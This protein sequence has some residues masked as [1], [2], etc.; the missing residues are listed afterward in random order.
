MSV[1]GTPKASVTAIRSAM[2]MAS[3]NEVTERR[4]SLRRPSR[5]S[6]ASSASLA[7]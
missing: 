7:A 6:R 5:C 4:F 1:T 2:L 3:A